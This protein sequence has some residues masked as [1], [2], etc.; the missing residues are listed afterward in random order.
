MAVLGI[1]AGGSS[2]KV[3]LREKEKIEKKE[4]FELSREKKEFLNLLEKI[5][6]IF[7]KNKKI[8]KIGVGLAGIL[9][10]KR[11]TVVRAPNIFWLENI[12]IKKILQ[13]R[14]KRKIFIENDVNCFALGEKFFGQAKNFDYFI[15]LVLGSGIGGAIFING[16]IIL[17]ENGGAGEIGHTFLDI[18]KKLDFE[19]LA[20]TK[21]LKRKLNKN[22]LQAK[23]LA[24]KGDKRAI[25]A[26]KLLGRNLGFGIV[27]L[28]HIFDPQA[29]ILGGG[30]TMSKNFFEKEMKKTIKK[31][32]ISKS[33]KTKILF[34]KLGRFGGAIGAT[35]IEN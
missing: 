21:F 32:I 20:S 10:K 24:K 16:K 12:K 17:G 3:V 29:I 5:Y 11:E 34:S 4:V 18:E 2:V 33:Y 25:E 9:D 6:R 22:S 28:I 7:S 30:V 35:F 19:N 8:E 15:T 13:E 31:F 23:M 26:F 1:D 27:N 14:L